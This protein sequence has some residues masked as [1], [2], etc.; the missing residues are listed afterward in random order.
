MKDQADDLRQ[1]VRQDPAEHAS[2]PS[3]TPALVAV[4]GG[5][6]GVGTTTLALNLAAA[7]SR[8]GRP[9][10][11]VDGDFGGPGAGLLCPRGDGPTVADVLAARCGLAD[12][13][14]PGPAG[15]RILPNAWPA[16]DCSSSAQERLIADLRGLGREADF[17]ILD[18]GSGLGGVVRRFWLAADLVLL[19][20]TPEP[21]SVMGAYAAVKVLLADSARVPI[22]TL[23]NLAPDAPSA[24]E[25]HGRLARAC[26]RFLGLE[27]RAA[28]Y[29][30]ADPEVI[31]AGRRG[32]SFL[33]DSPQCEASLRIDRLADSVAAAAA[34]NRV[35]KFFH[36]LW[37]HRKLAV[38]A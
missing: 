31:E 4:T 15:A 25:V 20:A 23:V 33:V 10:I 19:V 30:P 37:R 21:A 32:R 3:Q 17:V 5:K 2:P 13:L 1:L 36:R 12:A 29:V 14:R 24:S 34:G 28:G 9:T 6:G 16:A 18:A 26:Q 22:H 27:I 8:Q 38:P 11:L 7:L 35:R